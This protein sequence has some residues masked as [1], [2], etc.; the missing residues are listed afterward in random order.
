M[1]TLSSLTFAFTLLAGSATAFAQ[2]PAGGPPGGGGPGRGKMKEACKADF[3]KHCKDAMEKRERGAMRECIAAHEKDFSAGCKAAIEE[4]KKWREE[5]GGK[6]GPG[7]P[8]KGEGKPAD[9][10]PAAPAK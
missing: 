8:G 4:M 1:R 5:H 7:G 3:E 2:P 10:A 9:K 6:R